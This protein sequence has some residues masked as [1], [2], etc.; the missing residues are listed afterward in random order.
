M[1]VYS[2]PKEIPAPEVDYSNYN[3]EKVAAD[4]AKHKADL[5]AY[6]IKGGYTGKNTGKTI[7][8]QV[9]DGYAVYMLAEGKTSCLVHLP[10]GDGYEYRDVQ[11]IPKAEILRRV[12]SEEAFHAIFNS[13]S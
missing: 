2:L 9:A 3:H 4:E 6:L 13:K 7:R 8:F 12:K 10:Y 5:K 11:Y 1:K